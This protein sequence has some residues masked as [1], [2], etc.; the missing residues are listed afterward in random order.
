ML[1]LNSWAGEAASSRLR[2]VARNAVIL[3]AVLHP[4]ILHAAANLTDNIARPLHFHPDNGAFVVENGRE[5]FNRPLYGTN[6]AFRVDAGDQPEFVLYLPGRGG[7]LRL[8]LKKGDSAKW[9]FDAGHI[10]ARYLPGSMIYEIRDPILG[11]NATLRLTAIPSDEIQGLILR[12]ELHGNASGVELVYVYGGVN[13]EKGSRGG[14][15][16]AERLPVSEFFQ[17][18]PEF[19]RGNEITIRGSD[20]TLESKPATI[21]GRAPPGSRSALS[22]ATQWTSLHGLLAI[23]GRPRP[24]LQVVVTQ[25]ALKQGEPLFFALLRTAE[26][27]A[28]ELPQLF[29]KAER[30]RQEIAGQLVVD[31]PDPFI[32]AAAAALCVAADGIWDSKEKAFMH[33]AVAWRRPLL[34]WRGAYSGDALGWHD[35]TRTHLMKWISQQ[36]TEPVPGQIPAPEEKAN[37]SRNENALHSN[38]DLSKSHYDMNLLAI[39]ALFRHLLWTGDLDFAREVWPAIERHLAWERRLFRREFTA[40]IPPSQTGKDE[41]TAGRQIGPERLPLYE[42]YACIWASDDLYYSGGGTTHSS[43]LNFYHNKMAARVA[44]LIGQDSEP[45]QREADLI[46]RGVRKHLWLPE[47]G[48]FA[49]SKDLLGLQ[50]THDSP[51]LWTFYHTIDS[52]VPTPLEAWQMSRFVD[53]QIAHI[54]IRG[55]GVPGENLFTLPTSNWMPYT[56]STNNVVMAECAH[57]ALALWRAQRG[58]EAFRLFKGC[59]LDSMFMGLCPGNVGM[60]TQFDMAR[61]ESQRDFADGVGATSRALVEGLFGVRADALAGELRLEPGFPANWDHAEVRHRDVTFTFERNETTEIVSVEQRFAKPMR[62]R[63]R[64]PAFGRQ[65]VDTKVNGATVQAREVESGDGMHF[66]DVDTP[67]APTLKIAISWTGGVESQWEIASTKVI[68]VTPPQTDW[69]TAVGATRLDTVELTAVFNDRVTQIFKHEYLS[70]RSPFCSLAIPKQGIGSWCHPGETFEV[71]DSGLRAVAEKNGGRLVL[72]NGIEFQTP[73]TGDAKN[74]AFVS[75]WDNFPREMVV[76]LTGKASHVYLLMAGS[77]NSMQSRFDNGEVIVTYVD[78]STE[79]LALENP[80][81]WW[82]IQEDY[83]IDDF[84]F[85][86]PEPIPPRVDLKTGKVRVLDLASFKGKGGRIEGGSATVLDLPLQPGQELKSLTVR[87]LANDVVI[88]LMSATLLRVPQ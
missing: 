21:I 57:T 81:T 35:R 47:R 12:A 63:L 9:L 87:A 14:D 53:T 77:T 54:P 73:G 17:F 42:A 65:I 41:G 19:C 13:G 62:V 3:A 86:R 15:I 76:P 45:Y 46:A 43:A 78:G 6:T 22:D 70:P 84:A 2:E 69:E 39:D 68:I 51:A 82:P 7:N 29:E 80:T 74:I 52:E 18:K 5:F 33:G 37:L 83:R 26:T 64:V 61:G 11:E 58:D 56:W 4:A 44:K 72:P 60:C 25:A 23:A 88:G 38:G 40:G 75:Q 28:I 85:R 27:A 30:H 79:R 50:R 66:I 8:G 24:E 55:P 10:K 32:N 34:G 71:D 59:L 36:N 31:T 20:F 49:E 16:G 1:L 48:W 67:E